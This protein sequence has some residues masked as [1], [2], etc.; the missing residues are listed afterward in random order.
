MLKKMIDCY[1][2]RLHLNKENS[3]TK[4]DIAYCDDMRKLKV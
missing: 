2:K 4:I 3:K 1:V